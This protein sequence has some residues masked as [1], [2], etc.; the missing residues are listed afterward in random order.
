MR[1]FTL[2]LQQALQL[3]LQNQGFTLGDEIWIKVNNNIIYTGTVTAD[4]FELWKCKQKRDSQGNPIEDPK[5][6]SVWIKDKHYPDG[7][8]HLR[9]R[10]EQ[11]DEIF[12][13][14]NHP[15]GGIGAGH[16]SRFNKIF[17]ECDDRPI[18]LQWDLLQ[19]TAEKLHIVPSTVV[20]SGG[21]SL[22]IYYKL[23]VDISREQWQMLQRKLIIIFKSDKAIQNPNREMRLAG[24][25]RTKK[26]REQTLDKVTSATYSFD[27]LNT[28]L[29][30]SGKF[31]YGLSDTRWSDWRTHGDE[32]LALPEDE[33]PT[34]IQRA[35]QYAKQSQKRQVTGFLGSSNLV[36]LVKETSE[37]LGEDAFNWPGHNWKTRGNKS[38][39]CC[40][41]H[42]SQSKTSGWVAPMKNSTG[43]GYACP[44]CTDNK[45][46][47]AFT[48]WLGLRK[49]SLGYFPSGKEWVELAKEFLADHGVIAPELEQKQFNNYGEP[50]P[51]LYNEY[52]QREQEQ[53]KVDN[54]L[55]LLSF[56]ESFKQ[57]ASKVVKPIE[58]IF[59][60]F[61]EQPKTTAKLP[62]KATEKTVLYYPGI[63][64]HPEQI[65]GKTLII[66]AEQDK[67]LLAI[68]DA[69]YSG[70]RDILWQDD[71]GVGKSYLAGLLQTDN[72]IIK[73][74]IYLAAD[75]ANPT[76][77]TI[78]SNFHPVT[79]RHNGLHIDDSRKT[80]LG[81][82]YQVRPQ[83]GQSID[84][85]GNCPQNDLFNK[86]ESKNI[87]VEGTNKI[88]E[89]C[90]L[91]QTYS[92][93]FKQDRSHDLKQPRIRTHPDTLPLPTN[94]D[95][96]DKGLIWDEA[97]SLFKSHK[98][99]TITKNDIDK[100]I[101]LI[102]QHNPEILE[103]LQ[104]LFDRLYKLVNGDFDKEY[105][106][107]LY[108]FSDSTLR[109]ILP[110]HTPINL[111]GLILKVGEATQPELSFLEDIN[112][113]D[114][115]D[116]RG[117]KTAKYASKV[118]RRESYKDIAQELD[119]LGIDW[120]FD[121]LPAWGV[122]NCGVLSYQ[123]GRLTITKRDVQHLQLANNARFNLYLDAT[124]SRKTLALKRG[125]DPEQILVIRRAK[126]DYS[127]L[128]VKHITGLGNINGDRSP[129]KQQRVAAVKQKI[130]KDNPDNASIEW[131]QH[132]TENDGYHFRDGR[133]QNRF[134]DKTTLA[135]YGVPIQNV[136]SLANEFQLLTGID[137]QLNQEFYHPEFVEYLQEH[138]QGEII[139]EV[140]RLR[141]HRK[142]DQHHTV[143]FC[144]DFK[145]GG[146]EFLQEYFPGC[147]VEQ[148]E[149]SKFT[150]DAGGKTERLR[151][152]IVQAAKQI[153]E[154][155][156]KLTQKAIASLAGV[157]Q[158]RISQ[159]AA[160]F[161][162]WPA[163][164][165]I[166]ISLLDSLYRK[167]NN[168]SGPLTENQQ[169]YVEQFLPLLA[170]EKSIDP[171]DV[172]TT[173]DDIG[174]EAEV[175][176]VLS[177]VPFETKLLLIIKILAHI[178]DEF[179]EFIEPLIP[180]ETFF[181][182][183]S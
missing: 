128:T 85:P 83:K 121:F 117:D 80:S 182:E 101:A 162:G 26:G 1:S 16:C 48:Y 91:F 42:D 50:D 115:K 175:K 106:H 6:G 71:P 79:R 65:K 90:I 44:T 52:V 35:K 140:A 74:L 58:K 14:P 167:T 28:A 3:Q 70:Y 180:K 158:G 141:S 2:T 138:T 131:K 156:E 103:V 19:E 124:V 119:N 77:E 11:G 173:L 118:L 31:P 151:Y 157:T 21:K 18:T 88:C 123:W 95:Y 46:I 108:G 129:E 97:G 32:V 10:S 23:S 171:T 92:C 100:A 30:K 165:K 147:K 116:T 134:E 122:Y 143:Y 161:G 142:P 179:K 69:I 113:L 114:R 149:A 87:H 64:K 75:H 76:T 148:I 66:P 56:K 94:Y 68:W 111:L 110:K 72:I 57:I 81:N 133:G 49:G 160:D 132:A 27:E 163:L 150:P 170:G 41:W 146:L 159:V 135:I 98:S 29:D 104:P 178:P 107:G 67:A 109:E 164:K 25:A 22:H 78:E 84:I 139:Q 154:T 63:F 99:I 55:A 120:L 155:G 126:P 51:E 20:Y 59:K 37:R 39:G 183:T 7:Y 5:G 152:S 137:P 166:L 38:R 102:Y 15:I 8:K 62:I 13:I 93:T 33:L 82:P 4:G 176:L 89:N 53:E 153:W 86:L 168:F 105:K 130:D 54:Y 73:Q 177:R 169:F 9:Q 45:Q 172:A 12:F 144:G 61:G 36:D 127:N 181:Q 34:N 24:F 174:D 40:P 96:S 17:A 136:G 47:D 145:Q 60:G 125:I 43:W 112:G